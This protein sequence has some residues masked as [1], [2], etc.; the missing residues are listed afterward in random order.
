MLIPNDSTCPRCG[1]TTLRRTHENIVCSDCGFRD[2][3]PIGY[4]ALYVTL[5][6]GSECRL[7]CATD[8]VILWQHPDAGAT[9]LVPGSVHRFSGS[10][11]WVPF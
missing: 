6:D 2:S 8:G 7:L 5:A 4:A 3:V 11:G 10:Y 9:I 1:A